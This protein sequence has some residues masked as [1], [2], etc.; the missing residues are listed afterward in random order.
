MRG[1][2]WVAGIGAGFL[3][4][5]T[6]AAIATFQDW[7]MNPGGIYHDAQRTAWPFVLDTAS[8]WFAPVAA[9]ATLF[10]W[11]VLFVLSRRR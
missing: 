10:A 5:V 4:G 11:L 6:V 1:L 2:Y 9:M 7:R 8:S 3:T